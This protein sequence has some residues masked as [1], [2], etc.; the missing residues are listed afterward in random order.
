MARCLLC[1]KKGVFLKV[2][3]NGLCYPCDEQVVSETE[4]RQDTINSCRRV[5][6]S[7]KEQLSVRLSCYDKLMD[8]VNHLL[9]FEERGIPT[10]TPKP[11]EFISHFAGKRD[12]LESFCSEP[13]GKPDQT[14]TGEKSLSETEVTESLETLC[15]EKKKKEQI[16]IP[17]QIDLDRIPYIPL[18]PSPSKWE[19]WK[20]GTDELKSE[21]DPFQIVNSSGWKLT[22]S[23]KLEKEEKPET[24]YKE[25]RITSEGSLFIDK[26]G[27]NKKY[28][29][30][31]SSLMKRNR[32][33][34]VVK[35]TGLDH[36]IY[37][38]A[39]SPLNDYYAFMS[40]E[41]VLYAYNGKLERIFEHKLSQDPRI[42]AHYES[43][44]PTWGSIKSHIR[45]IDVST[46]GKD[47]LFT[48][49]DTAWCINK[50]HESNW[51][52]SMPLNEGWERVVSRTTTAGPREESINALSEL[53]LRMPVTQEAIKRKYRELAF[54]WHPDR[55][56]DINAKERMQKINNAF[57]MLT[58]VNPNSLEIREKTVFDYRKKPDFTFDIDL[59]GTNINVC[60]DYPM[61]GI[62]N[63]W[64][65]ASGFADDQLHVYLGSYAGKIVKVDLKGIPLMV[66]DVSNTP[67]WIIDTSDYLYIQTDTR[68][69][70]IRNGDELV[71]IKDIKRKE[72]LIVG[73]EGFGLVG[74]KF[75][76]WFNEDGKD[77]GT[78]TTKDPIRAVYL[79]RQNMIVE[80]RQ[81]RA[82]LKLSDV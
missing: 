81:H 17:R 57:S 31:K 34:N 41:G 36:D 78:I 14:T 2:T 54:K 50:N 58:G 70:I 49:A 56:K 27:K 71:D 28:S 39:T 40:G 10:I 69:Y 65:Y 77:I 51:G 62:P 79:S 21:K 60:L 80:T 3:P 82:V 7:S 11:S 76:K 22:E 29:G 67:R 45:T 38:I 63:D 19:E 43:T 25:I 48:I 64:I 46:E 47:Y 8:A 32:E 59:E 52:I 9:E 66:Y 15:I 6:E 68:L 20:A 33:G 30:C 24:F 5:V 74:N 26:I 44:I 72:K 61:T 53:D 73:D 1:D 12:Q 37:R 18:P 4:D 23:R 35:E 75:L 13:N 55:N 42:V 16:Y